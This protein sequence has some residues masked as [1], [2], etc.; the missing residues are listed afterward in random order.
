M[1]CRTCSPMAGFGSGF[2]ADLPNLPG[3]VSAEACDRDKEKIR[4]DAASSR[5]LA[6]GL[7]AAVGIGVGYG[8]WG[9]KR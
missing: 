6:I 3:Y 2:G 5:W 1:K 7:A 9:R 8:L 4:A